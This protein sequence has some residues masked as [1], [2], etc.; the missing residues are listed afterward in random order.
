MPSLDITAFCVALIPDLETAIAGFGR[1]TPPNL[2]IFG[3]KNPL[4]G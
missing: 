1:Y 3:N 2:S 4:A